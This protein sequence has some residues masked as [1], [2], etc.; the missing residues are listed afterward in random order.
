MKDYLEVTITL[1]LLHLLKYSKAISGVLN[2]T[3][4][5]IAVFLSAFNNDDDFVWIIN[6]DDHCVR[7]I[8]FFE[9]AGYSAGA[10]EHS[11]IYV[12]IRTASNEVI[13]LY[14]GCIMYRPIMYS[15]HNFPCTNVTNE[16]CIS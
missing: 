4:S 5:P 16:F 15:C 3:G 2:F 12:V 13:Y 8:L 1:L 10:P 7:V 11:H 9:V 14:Q 6:E